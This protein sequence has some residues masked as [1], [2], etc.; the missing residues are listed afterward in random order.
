[1]LALNFVTDL[2]EH[3]FV[4]TKYNFEFDPTKD[5]ANIAKHGLSLAEAATLEMSLARVSI[6]R[7][8]DYGEERFIAVGPLAGRLHVLIFALRGAVIRVISLRKANAREMR[9]Y[10]RRR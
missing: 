9:D 8:R 10:D 1:M 4:A 3:Y 2:P 6:D 7:R 5:A